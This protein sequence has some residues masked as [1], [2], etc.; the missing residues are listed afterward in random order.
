VQGEPAVIPIFA[1]SKIE[2]IEEN[3][4]ALDIVLSEEHKK[5]LEHAD[6]VPK[7]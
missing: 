4:G 5:K 2:Q 6:A 7:N 3:L 1:A